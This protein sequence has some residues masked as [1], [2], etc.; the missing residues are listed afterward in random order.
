MKVYTPRER[1]AGYDTTPHLIE[2]KRW[3]PIDSQKSQGLVSL[4]L[5]SYCGKK[6]SISKGDKYEDYDKEVHRKKLCEECIRMVRYSM[7]RRDGEK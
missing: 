7:K 2:K 3:Y 6:L 5:M 1:Y 4:T